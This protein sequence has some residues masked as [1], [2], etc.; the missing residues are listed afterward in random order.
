MIRVRATGELR[1]MDLARTRLMAGPLTLAAALALPAAAQAHG[2]LGS[3]TAP[4]AASSDT[5]ALRGCYM[6]VAVTPRPASVLQNAFGWDVDP[7]A[8]FYGPDPLLSVWALRCDSA[9]TRKARTKKVLLSFVGV[10]TGA[11]RGDRP[12]AASL[13]A[14]GINRVETDSAAMSAAL[15]D[16]GIPVLRA[17]RASYKHAADGD[18]VRA[19]VSIPGEYGVKMTASILD[20]PHD[21]FNSFE[22]PGRGRLDLVTRGANDRFC[23]PISGTCTAKI[24]G[25]RR[26]LVARALGAPAADASIAFDHLKIKRIDITPRRDPS[27]RRTGA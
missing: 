1:G 19:S 6:T 21:H 2:V 8:T 13:F 14:H 7:V 17:P 27:A 20:Q 11:T 3:P 25:A 5:I 24:S 10:P 18:T 15:A 16:S 22:V 4:R 26:S 9:T 12:P 23:L